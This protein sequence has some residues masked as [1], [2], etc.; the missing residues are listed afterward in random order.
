MQHVGYA[1]FVRVS[2]QILS[3]LSGVRS[4]KRLIPNLVVDSRSESLVRMI[5]TALDVLVANMTVGQDSEM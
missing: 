1:S 4:R 5:G 3:A 2:F